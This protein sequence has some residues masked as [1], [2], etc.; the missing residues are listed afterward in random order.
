MMHTYPGGKHVQVS[1]AHHRHEALGGQHLDA[2]A[3]VATRL[4]RV[5]DDGEAVALKELA[6]RG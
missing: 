3:G 2:A 5:H 6:N 1:R 4:D